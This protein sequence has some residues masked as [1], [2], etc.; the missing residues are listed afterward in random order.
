MFAKM[1]TG[2]KVLAGFGIAIVVAVVVGL[3]GYRGISKLGVHV[4]RNRHERL[5]SVRGLNLIQ[6]ATDVGYADRGLAHRPIHGTQ[7][8]SASQYERIEDGLEEADKGLEDVRTATEDGRKKTV[9]WKEFEGLGTTWTES[10]G[11]SSML[12]AQ[13]DSL[14]E[15]AQARRRQGREHRR[16]GLC[17]RR[18]GTRGVRQELRT[19]LDRD[20]SSS[21]PSI[22]TKTRQPSRQR[23]DVLDR[24][25]VL[26]HRRGRGAD[27]GSGR[28]PRQE[29][30]QGAHGPDR[31]GE[32]ADQG[33]RRTASS[34]PAATPSW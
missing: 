9:A 13:K 18:A 20:R 5:P 28:V 25:D 19:K 6:G 8:R 14:A 33:G 2:T 22:A 15:G 10:T 29:H 3:V 27:A 21:T 23:R 17:N 16:Q 26:R 12:L 32:S 31:R 24:D 7:T 34:R 4:E 1:K 30:L 11:D